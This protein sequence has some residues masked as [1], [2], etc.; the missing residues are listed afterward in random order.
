VLV[1]QIILSY[2]ANV[3]LISRRFNVCNLQENRSIK[4]IKNKTLFS[5][6]FLA[7]SSSIDFSRMILTLGICQYVNIFNSNVTRDLCKTIMLIK[8]ND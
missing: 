7:K 6:N 4:D 1:E 8:E 2:L 5:G 3:N